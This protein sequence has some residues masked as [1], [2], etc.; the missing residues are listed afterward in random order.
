M[1]SDDDALDLLA[2]ASPWKPDW[3]DALERAGE[4]DQRRRQPWAGRRRI[5]ALVASV[6]LVIPL[7]VLGAETARWYFEF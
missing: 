5:L 4:L 3:D 6:M 7:I 2:P 1:T